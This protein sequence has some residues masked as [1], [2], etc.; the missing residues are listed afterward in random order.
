MCSN[1]PF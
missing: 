1:H